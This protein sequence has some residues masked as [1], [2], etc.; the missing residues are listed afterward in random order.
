MAMYTQC[1][2]F[3]VLHISLCNYS[4]LTSD[5]G[6]QSVHFQASPMLRGH[7]YCR[8]SLMHVCSD[9]ETLRH[10]WTYEVLLTVCWV[11]VFSSLFLPSHAT[12][13][14]LGPISTDAVTV[15][16]PNDHLREFSTPTLTEKTACIPIASPRS[17][18]R[19]VSGE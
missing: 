13:I 8:H 14:N 19:C 15:E 5:Q 4:P 9:V 17:E 16:F 2:S 12:K 1:F 18:Q 10:P 7:I 6:L 11:R 3:I